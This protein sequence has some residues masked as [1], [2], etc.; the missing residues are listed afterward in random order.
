MGRWLHDRALRTVLVVV[1]TDDD[2]VSVLVDA[3]GDVVEVSEKPFE[4]QLVRGVY[5]FPQRLLLI[6]GTDRAV[7]MH[8]ARSSDT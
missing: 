6:L 3:I 8:S 4:A 2:A 7:Q 5:K 1:Q